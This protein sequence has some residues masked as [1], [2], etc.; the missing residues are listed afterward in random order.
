MAD[1]VAAPTALM[2][3]AARSAPDRLASRTGA[4]AVCEVSTSQA[5]G[6][7]PRIDDR[8]DAPA[9]LGATVSPQNPKTP[10]PQNPKTPFI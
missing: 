4:T 1:L 8:S 7:S 6:L 5:P 10:K 2:L 9:L 3:M